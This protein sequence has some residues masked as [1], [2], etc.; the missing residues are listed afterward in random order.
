MDDIV[1]YFKIAMIIPIVIVFLVAIIL[2]PIAL[3]G[4]YELTYSSNYKIDCEY[5]LVWPTPNFKRISSYFGK[6]N[7]PTAGASSYHGG[8]DVLAYQGTDVLSVLD[9]R[10]VFAGWS[11][12]GGYMVKIQHDNDLQSSYCHL[13]EILCVSKGD[14][15]SKGQVIG[16]V[17][18]KYLSNGKLNGATTGVH[19][20]FAI[21]KAGKAVNPLDF[22]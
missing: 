11:N 14:R 3:E 19:L 18:P 7:S 20:H 2:I 9:G 16:T 8:V 17:G 22:F 1:S 13:G 4:G 5:D 21:S 12:S 10:V 15:V 6:R